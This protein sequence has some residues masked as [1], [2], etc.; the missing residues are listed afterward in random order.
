M[1]I[2]IVPNNFNKDMSAI[3]LI[4]SWIVREGWD[5]STTNSKFPECPH[6]VSKIK[7]FTI[8]LTFNLCL[9]CQEIKEKQNSYSER[10]CLHRMVI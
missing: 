5:L 10:M 2:L 8:A 3:Y 1:L 9:L 4:K 7:V 6:L